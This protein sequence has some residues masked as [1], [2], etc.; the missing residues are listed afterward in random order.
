M[1]RTAARVVEAAALLRE[2]RELRRLLSE[3]RY[4]PLKRLGRCSV[5]DRPCD[6]LG[7]EMPE[8]CPLPVLVEHA[9]NVVTTRG[10][11]DAA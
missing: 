6:Y 2:L 11:N 1:S 10:A 4:C 9:D 5:T 7:Y 8:H 3:D